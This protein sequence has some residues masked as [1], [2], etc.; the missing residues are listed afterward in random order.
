MNFFKELSELLSRY[1]TQGPPRYLMAAVVGALMGLAFF[2]LATLLF[3]AF[4]KI[5]NIS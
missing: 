2:L 3:W 5:F 1:A 4:P